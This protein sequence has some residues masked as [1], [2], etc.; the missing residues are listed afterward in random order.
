VIWIDCAAATVASLQADDDCSISLLSN[1]RDMNSQGWDELMMSWRGCRFCNAL[2]VVF[3]FCRWFQ[4]QSRR[5]SEIIRFISKNVSKIWHRLRKHIQH[6]WEKLYDENEWQNKMSSSFQLNLMRTSLNSIWQSYF[7][8]ISHVKNNF[9]QDHLSTKQQKRVFC[10][11]RESKM[12][13]NRRININSKSN[14][15]IID[16]FFWKNHIKDM[17]EHMIVFYVWNLH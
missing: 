8:L 6:E 5:F 16:D 2:T 9:Q 7:A 11:L 10:S 12:N 13:D 14:I 3:R 4:L 1:S 15:Q 17:N